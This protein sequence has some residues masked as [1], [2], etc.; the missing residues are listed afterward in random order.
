MSA[1]I[2]ARPRPS[3]AL[4]VRPLPEALV[5][6]H[7][8]ADLV[9]V[10]AGTM[11]VWTAWFAQAGGG[12]SDGSVGGDRRV[13][14]L[15]AWGAG[16][17]RA[18]SGDE[19]RITRAS[20]GPDRLYP[21]WSRRALELWKRHE[22]EWGVDLFLPSGVLWFAADPDGWEARS[23]AVLGELGI[24]TERLSPDELVRRWPQIAVHGDLSFIL[25]EPE[26][27]VL[28]AR[29]GCLAVTS[30]FQRAGGIYAVAAVRPGRS[31]GSRLVEVVD[32]TG[33]TWSA[34][35]FVFACGPWLPR[36]FPDVLG[37]VIRVTKQDI[38]FVGPPAGDQRFHWRSMPAWCD[39]RAAYYGIG[40]TDV[41][42]MKIA[43]D[44]YGPIFDPTSGERVVDPDSMRLVRDY[45]RRRFPALGHAP[46]VESRVCQ[47]ETT[48]DSHFVIARHPGL[49][50]V[51]LLGGG[52][53]HGFKHGPRV[54]EYLV[55]RL[56]GLPE[57]AQDGDD[58]MRF[59]IG[60]RLPGASTRTDAD[61]MSATW[62]P[63]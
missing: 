1:S 58:E 26:G 7:R 62:E 13:V 30:A 17:P 42:G 54:G 33:R 34:D 41:S 5:S 18:T 23:Q 32:R 55:G 2:G 19:T 39:Y 31:E 46:M 24:P 12:G 40:A 61:G 50:N 63:L 22:R 37:S 53:G 48:I 28:M 8:T 43:P 49:D 36:L 51:W 44:R 52:S 15:D 6:S 4:G 25:H 29:R 45:L 3:G 11:G 60:P 59:R 27:G 38:L 21:A 56:D 20:H 14:L 10:G 35:A 47:Y 16:H 9:V 57:G